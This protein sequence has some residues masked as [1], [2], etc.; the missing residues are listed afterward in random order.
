MSVQSATTVADVTR[1][2]RVGIGPVHRAV[3]PIKTIYELLKDSKVRYAPK[4]QRGFK[5]KFATN[6]AKSEYDRLFSLNDPNLQISQDRAAEMAVKYIKASNNDKN[7]ML[8]SSNVTWNARKEKGRPEPEYDAAKKTLSIHTSITVPDTGHRHTAYFLVGHWKEH[9][10]EIPAQVLVNQVPVTQAEIKK[11]L[12]KVDLDDYSQHSIYVDIYCLDNEME[13]WLYDE[14]NSDSKPPSR[15][16]ALNL[17]KQKTPTRRFAWALVASSPIFS[18][19][20]VEGRS[21]TI[22]AKSKKLT[23]I[24][25]L[26]SAAQPFV[27]KL[28]EL[29]ADRDAG[30]SKQYDD[31]LLFFNAF[32]HEWG[33]HFPA[34]MPKA[35]FDERE[36]TRNETFAASNIMF[37]PLFRLAFENWLD[38]QTRKKDWRK[39]DEWKTGLAKIGGSITVSGKKMKVM[40]RDNPAWQGKILI[41]A[42]DNKGKQVGWSLSSTRQTRDAAYAYLKE[43]FAAK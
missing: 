3:V 15:A 21:N 23:T 20:E 13:G 17:N 39:A 1:I 34:F 36:K 28:V 43:I 6:V 32:F 9:P 8:F 24:S 27:K 40:S 41:A 38:Y 5:Q 10:E 11:L 33:T 2:N 35:S 31:L 37:F 16:V 26:E 18:E 19:D 30:V 42:F 7:V 12:D 22:A 14:F 29:E 4:Y 25:T